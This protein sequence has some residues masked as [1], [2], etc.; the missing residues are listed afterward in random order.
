MNKGRWACELLV[1]F[2]LLASVGG[3]SLRNYATN[4]IGDTLAASGSGFASDDDP[5]LIAA[6]A[7]FSLKLMESV[8][9]ETP[10]HR[11]LLTAAA[12]GFVQYAYAFVQQ[13]ADEVESRDLETAARLR[14]RARQLYLRARDYGLR[15]LEVAH[16]GFATRVHADPRAA[17]AET[18]REDAADLYWTAVAW[19]AAISLSK[20]T[21]D[22]VAEL[23]QVDELV[24]CLA[25]LDPDFDHGS[26]EGF[27]ISYAM[28]RP[29]AVAG[30]ARGA[31]QH[32]ERALRLTSGLKAGPY[33][34]YA[35]AVS[36]A[37]QRRDEF[38]D[39]IKQA[40]AV[41]PGARPQWRLENI[42]M[43]RRA[44]WLLKNTDQLFVE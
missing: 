41:D 11:G 22:R 14:V 19:A 33:V 6:A 17:V 32:F 28:A 37:E 3:C 9:D 1:L 39:L 29:E 24:V 15:A 30:G 42:V 34:A 44:R 5:E 36:V 38:T 25:K 12:A 31:R 43:Q 8:L 21:A 18:T 35:E 40:L 16:P 10:R 7:P 4:K 26:L 27:L 2:M 23:P 20:D 13:E